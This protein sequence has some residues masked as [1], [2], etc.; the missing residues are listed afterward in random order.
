M[1]IPFDYSGAD[2][3]LMGAVPDSPSTQYGYIIPET[4]ASVSFVSTFKEKPDAATAEK[5]IEQGAL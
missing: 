1:Q 2:I 5:Y 4:E 3:A